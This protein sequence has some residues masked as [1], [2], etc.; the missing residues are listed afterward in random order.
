MLG[1]A[2]GS[3]LALNASGGLLWNFTTPGSVDAVSVARAEGGGGAYVLAAG[4]ASL[5]VCTVPGGDVYGFEVTV[6][7]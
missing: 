7:V 1:T 6:T 4:C 2:G 5:G 3:I